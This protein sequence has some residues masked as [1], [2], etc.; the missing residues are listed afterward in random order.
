LTREGY[1][2]GTAVPVERSRAA[3]EAELTKRGATAFGYNWTGT[4]AVVAFTLNGL[5]VRMRLALPDRAD[6][7]DYTAGNR[8]RVAGQKVHDD[9]VRRRWRALFL[10]V[11]AKLVAV[12]EGITSLE[13]EFLA[14]VVLPAGVT[15]LEAVRPEIEQARAIEGRPGALDQG[16]A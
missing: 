1:A 15:V 14:D 4:E 13:R 8:R 9:E 5:L 6:Y 12:D 11:K 2:A 7:Q 10:V 16:R 3:I